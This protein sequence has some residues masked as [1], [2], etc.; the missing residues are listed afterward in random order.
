ME[1]A[2]VSARLA[3]AL[4]MNDPHTNNA[5]AQPHAVVIC[6]TACDPPTTAELRV[7]DLREQSLMQRARTGRLTDRVPRRP[8]SSTGGA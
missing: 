6:V 2:R 7:R 3:P 8:A 4:F 5:A 1:S